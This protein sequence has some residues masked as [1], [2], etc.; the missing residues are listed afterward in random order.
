MD[1]QEYVIN[2]EWYIVASEKLLSN[3]KSLGYY[4]KKVI[5]N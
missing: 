1:K 4:F 2:N 5:I 3:A